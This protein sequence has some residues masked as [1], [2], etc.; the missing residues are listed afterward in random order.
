[1]RKDGRN[2]GRYD[3][4]SIAVLDSSTALF[5]VFCSREVKEGERT[6]SALR[7]CTAD[8]L[9]E[10]SENNLTVHIILDLLGQ[11]LHTLH[12]DF[13]IQL[14]CHVYVKAN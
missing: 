8:Q 5:I 12:E 13:Q 2:D 1:M 14:S 7:Y 6:H 11:A 3:Y 4:F 10:H 9:A